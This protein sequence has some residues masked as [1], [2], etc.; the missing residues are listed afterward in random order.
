VVD[1][2]RSFD[3]LASV[4][5]MVYAMVTE[6]QNWPAL[7][8]RTDGDPM[9]LAPTVRQQVADLEPDPVIQ[10]LELLTTTLSQ[11][12]A[13]RRFVMILL[14]LFAGIALALAT[15]G[16]YGL[17]QYSTAQQ[18]HDIGIRMALGA[19][20]TDILRAVVGQGLKL[21]VLGV[22]VGLAGALILTRL[23]SSF[24]YGVT[25]TDPVTFVCV[26]LVL[27]GVALLASYLPARRAARVDPMTALRYE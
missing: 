12:L 15:I 24:L 2:V 10:T 9:R 22:A 4:Q 11:M 5:G 18:T 7:L 14:S 21:T 17:L 6:F 19:R 27:A 16:V 13:P 8:I 20:K 26:S 1:T 23:I 25:R 3:I